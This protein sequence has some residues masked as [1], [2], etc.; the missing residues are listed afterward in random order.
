M[1]NQVILVAADPD[2]GI[3]YSYRPNLETENSTVAVG[4]T[5]R[6]DLPPGA[7]LNINSCSGY[8]LCAGGVVAV[9]VSGK[10]TR[11]I[12]GRWISVKKGSF[13]TEWA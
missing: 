10:V 1:T 9:N 2:L 13:V 11:L 12:E 4:A 8:I 3:G 5:D 6:F 7:S